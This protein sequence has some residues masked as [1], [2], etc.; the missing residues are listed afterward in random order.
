MKISIEDIKQT[1]TKLQEIVAEM[2]LNDKT[3]ISTES[4]TYWCGA[5]F[6]SY[7]RNGFLDLDSAIDKIYESE[8]DE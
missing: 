3:D 4:N 1:I 8:E 5:N 6:I 7:G 2:E